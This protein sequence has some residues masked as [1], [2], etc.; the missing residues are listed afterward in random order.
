MFKLGIPQ[1]VIA[2]RYHIGI[3]SVKRLKSAY[4]RYGIEYFREKGSNK[5]YSA[6]YKLQIVKR[7]LKGESKSSVALDIKVNVGVVY[8]WCKKYENL[9][10][11]G[12][13]QDLR[14]V[15]MEKKKDTIKPKPKLTKHEQIKVLEKENEHLKMENDLLKKLQALVQQ[16]NKP[17]DKKK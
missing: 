11:N 4:R 12:L 9:G 17:Q 7:V 14:G 6:E 1:S 5:R 16:R 2:V 10:Y 15:H 8:A 13:K 3:T